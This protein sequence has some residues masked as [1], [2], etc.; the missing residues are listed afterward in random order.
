[1]IVKGTVI[2]KDWNTKF[3]HTSHRMENNYA[4]TLKEEM[5]SCWHMIITR[6]C[7]EFSVK[8]ILHQR[9]WIP[10]NFLMENV[11]FCWTVSNFHW[12]HA[13]ELYCLGSGYRNDFSDCVV[14]WELSL[15]CLMPC[16]P[17]W[18]WL[19][20][21]ITFH[22]KYYGLFCGWTAVQHGHLMTT[23][24]HVAWMRNLVYGG[25]WELPTL[26]SPVTG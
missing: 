26:R 5:T 10:Q 23:V 6:A 21:W 3:M 8:M 1:M 4:G 22:T 18:A 14:S 25:E 2:A 7:Q 12:E 24:H 19:P 13:R 9:M 20:S 15:E 17:L 16:S 11:D